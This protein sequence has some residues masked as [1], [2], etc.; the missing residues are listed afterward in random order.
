M[1]E[2]TQEL[3]YRRIDFKNSDG[4]KRKQASDGTKAISIEFSEGVVKSRLEDLAPP[5]TKEAVVSSPY[6]TH[7]SF[8]HT[9]QT[10]EEIIKERIDKNPELISK[11]LN[12]KGCKRYEQKS[13]GEEGAW[14]IE[15]YL[16][17]NDKNKFVKICES[18]YRG[19]K[20]AEL[21]E[22]YLDEEGK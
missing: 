9:P 5:Y 16:A 21:V 11:W 18:E 15:L 20:V 8:I 22:A 10:E 12:E 7:Y 1:K 19:T 14:Y 3:V 6:H 13:T 4:V 2:F 17:P